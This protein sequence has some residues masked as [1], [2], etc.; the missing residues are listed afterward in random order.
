MRIFERSTSFIA[1]IIVILIKKGLD[2]GK[3]KDQ[4]DEDIMNIIGILS[5]KGLELGNIKVQ[6]DE[7]RKTYVN[8]QR[9]LKLTRTLFRTKN[10]NLNVRE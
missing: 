8:N 7:D 4:K 3:T 5:K 2:L 9:R 6:T 10:N 1:Y